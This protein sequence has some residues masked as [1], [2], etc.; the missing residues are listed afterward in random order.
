MPEKKVD[1][2][3]LSSREFNHTMTKLISDVGELTASSKYTKEALD[4]LRVDVKKLNE[5]VLTELNNSKDIVCIKGNIKELDDR[6]EV[7]ENKAGN[8]AKGVFVKAAGYAGILLLG[9]ILTK[10]FNIVEEIIK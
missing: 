9:A 4:E 5:I 3:N 6:V 1:T 8:I 2:H 10:V 7:L